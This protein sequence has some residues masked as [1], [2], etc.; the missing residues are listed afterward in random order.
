MLAPKRRRGEGDDSSDSEQIDISNALAGKRQRTQPDHDSE[1]ELGDFIRTS[2]AKRDVKNG[3]EL[4]KKVKG[5]A[6]L[7][8]GEVGGG[9]FQSMGASKICI[10]LE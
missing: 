8:K 3:T 5:K 9:S 6:K 10:S 1:D 7:A 4:V 2:I